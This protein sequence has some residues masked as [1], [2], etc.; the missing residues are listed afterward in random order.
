MNAGHFLDGLLRQLAR[1]YPNVEIDVRP[2]LEV[3]D[4]VVV[5][6]ER[7]P[8]FPFLQLF[9]AEGSQISTVIVGSRYT[10]DNLRTAELLEFVSSVYESRFTLRARRFPWKVLSLTVTFN[11][12]SLGVAA[13]YSA[14]DIDQWEAAALARRP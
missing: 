9:T 4:I 14:S 6:L 2:A 11:G 5:N 10:F 12:T 1:R 3:P 8:E 13:S 7:G